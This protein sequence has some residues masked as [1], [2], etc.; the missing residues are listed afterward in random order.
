MINNC[1]YRLHSIC[2]TCGW[3]PLQATVIIAFALARDRSRV[4]GR[5]GGHC[6]HDASTDLVWEALWHLQVGLFNRKESGL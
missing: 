3:G 6:R 1:L 5:C 2:T 4:S